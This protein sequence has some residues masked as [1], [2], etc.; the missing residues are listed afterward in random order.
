MVKYRLGYA[1]PIDPMLWPNDL[2]YMSWPQLLATVRKF[3]RE[4]P[5][6]LLKAAHDA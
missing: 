2:R 4:H 5:D 1:S 6:Y 3:R